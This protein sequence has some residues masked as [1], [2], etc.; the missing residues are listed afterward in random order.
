MEKGAVAV[1]LRESSLLRKLLVST[2][3]AITVLFAVTGWIVQDRA[4]RLTTLSLEVEVQNG[5]RAYDALWRARAEMLSS[6]SLI[7]SRMPDVRAAFSTGDAATI[8]D[9]AGEIWGPLAR[10]DAVFLVCDP[11]GG[12]I[13]S[14]GRGPKTVATELPLVRSAAARFPRQSAG[15][16]I[17]GGTLFQLSLIHI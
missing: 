6:I 9:S 15:F 12:V 7:L 10:E 2:S 3:V 4:S 5:F 11:S 16:Q 1:R 17:L 8:R 14:L 13:A